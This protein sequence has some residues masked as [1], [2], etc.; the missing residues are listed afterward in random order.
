MAVPV[1]LAASALSNN[2]S[3]QDNKSN[4]DNSGIIDR[5]LQL[6]LVVGIILVVVLVAATALIFYYV[7][8]P[9]LG[10]LESLLGFVGN[11]ANP[12]G[13]PTASEVVLSIL[14]PPYFVYNVGSRAIGG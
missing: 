10:L 11:L 5:L 2:N 12:G 6:G 9:I 7:L 3:N 8:P 14:F 4:K 1:A 13:T